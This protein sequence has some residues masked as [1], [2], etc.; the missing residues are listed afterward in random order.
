MQNPI[1]ACDCVINDCTV[2]HVGNKVMKLDQIQDEI[3][4][5]SEF[6]LKLKEA[7]D[8]VSKM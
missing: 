2:L 4:T 8:E 3:D 1:R 5:K 7:M 6:G